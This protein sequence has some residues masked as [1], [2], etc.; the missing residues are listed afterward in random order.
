[1]RK[2]EAILIYR[3]EDELLAKG[4]EILKTELEKAGAKVSKEDDMKLRDL[5]YP[6]KKQTRGHYFLYDLEL[7]PQKVVE[8]EKVIKMSSE[9]LK[10]LFVK[11]EK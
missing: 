9:I 5:A 8:I 2:Y 1:M 7:D 4:K 6:I 3:A 11:K 10:Y